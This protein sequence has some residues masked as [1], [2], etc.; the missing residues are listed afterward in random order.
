M[1]RLS[2]F[3]F[4]ILCGGSILVQSMVADETGSEPY[5]GPYRAL[6]IDPVFVEGVRVDQGRIYLMLMPV[7]AKHPLQMKVS[8]QRGSIYRNWH[9]GEEVLVAPPNP[10]RGQGTWT[11]WIETQSNYIEY[12]MDEKLILHLHKVE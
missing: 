3:V 7:A 5:F 1:S 12:W 8:M 11:D 4:F 10:D 2:R 9:T 6:V